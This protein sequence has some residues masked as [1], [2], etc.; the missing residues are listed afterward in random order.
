LDVGCLLSYAAIFG[1]LLF[2]KEIEKRFYHPNC[3][4][5]KMVVL[6]ATTSTAQV[7]TM[8]MCLYYFH[9]FPILLL[10]SNLLAI[11]ITTY[12]LYSEIVIVLMSW[13]A[14]IAK[15]VAYLA[16]KLIL[17]LN[18]SILWMSTIPFFNI[19]NIQISYT[20]YFM[21]MLAMVAIS[22]AFI[23]KQFKPLL[24]GL[25]LIAVF[26]MIH[27]AERQQALQQQKI[28]VHNANRKSMVQLFDGQKYYV[29]TTD[30]IT[31]SD[32]R[33]ILHP[34]QLIY[35]ANT[36]TQWPITTNETMSMCVF[37]GKKIV[38]I[39]QK[40]SNATTQLLQVDYLILSHN[41]GNSLEALMQQFDCKQWI[42]DGSNSLWKIE[43]WK[44]EA[45]T[46]HLP[47]YIT[48]E[49]GAFVASLADD[50]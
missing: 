4:V 21:L 20:Q 26:W 40:F 30:T 16:T 33:N 22:W 27:I 8:P 42:A 39:N 35:R 19:D 7:F 24:V 5:K 17:F 46:L 48:A 43:Q 10:L 47:L 34:T 12:L 44:K 25:G 11:P 29:M 18:K 38:N 15:A 37:D 41:Q 2:A 36:P 32:V 9:Q 50:Q 31:A 49:Q 45:A 14:P 6:V 23:K 13:C 1:I 28:V 3:F